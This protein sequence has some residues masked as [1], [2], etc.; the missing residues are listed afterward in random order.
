MDELKIRRLQ[1]DILT[2]NGFGIIY[3]TNDS[4]HLLSAF[5]AYVC[6]PRLKS[7]AM[8]YLDISW[9]IEKQLIEKTKI[10]LNLICPT[11]F[12][13]GN[14]LEEPTYYGFWKRKG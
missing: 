14:R 6:D 1:Q 13:F 4:R 9:Q 3:G 8:F 10:H 11:G 5:N 2:L 7:F 12:Y